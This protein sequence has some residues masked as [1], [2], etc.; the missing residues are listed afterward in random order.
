M[1]IWLVSKYN[2]F[3]YLFVYFCSFKRDNAIVKGAR[4]EHVRPNSEH[5]HWVQFPVSWTL[6]CISTLNRYFSRAILHDHHSKVY[7]FRLLNKL[8]EQNSAHPNN[9][10]TNCDV[11]QQLPPALF[12]P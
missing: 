12:Q 1:L 7:V 9:Y 2:M 5:A 3:S 8:I 6:W 10:P 4:R 11:V